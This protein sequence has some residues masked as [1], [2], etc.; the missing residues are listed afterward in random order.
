[1]PVLPCISAAHCAGS[2]LL[3]CLAAKAFAA[4]PAIPATDDTTSDTRPVSGSTADPHTWPDATAYPLYPQGEA[5]IDQ[6]L[7]PEQDSA[8]DTQPPPAPWPGQDL[9]LNP[10]LP[11]KEAPDNKPPLLPLPLLETGVAQSRNLLGQTASSIGIGLDSIFGAPDKNQPNESSI[12]VRTGLRFEDGEDTVMVNGLRF[13]ADLPATESK[14]QLLIRL[15]DENDLPGRGSGGNGGSGS[16]PDTG[17]KAPTEPQSSV[18]REP[19]V[20]PPSNSQG[21]TPVS[22][23]FLEADKA[24][25]FFRYIYQPPDSLW[26]TTLDSGWQ[27]DTSDLSTEAVTYLRT[28]RTFQAGQWQLRPVPTLFWTE[29]AGP[30]IGITLHSKRQLDSITTLQNTT[31]I[32]YLNDEDTTYYQHGWQLI[33]AFGPDLRA[34]YNLTLY[35]SDQASEL[36]DEAQV[37]ATL[38]RRLSGDWLFFSVTPADTLEADNDYNSNFSITFQFEAKFGTQY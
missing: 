23:S 4:P 13:R 35:S 24:G 16:S 19:A 34:T 20:S 26:Q 27:L 10:Q 31:G 21:S 36:I 2:V 18:A 32:N 15:D 3:A 11:L 1:M 17:N 9:L 12:I 37:S 14:F 22:K 25:I 6:A 28:G 33:K 8:A 5:A 30:G 29:D 38:R 7:N